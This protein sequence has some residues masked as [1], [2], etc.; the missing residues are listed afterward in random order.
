MS[1]AALRAW[2]VRDPEDVV[3]D[4]TTRSS[5]GATQCRNNNDN[6]NVRCCDLHVKD[7][8]VYSN[9]TVRLRGAAHVPSSHAIDRLTVSSKVE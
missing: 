3:I 9:V 6:C 1:H 2:T 7:D 4:R 8:A 5:A